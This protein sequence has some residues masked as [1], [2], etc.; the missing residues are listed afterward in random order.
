MAEHII[1]VFEN[2]VTAASAM[3]S[4]IG[5]GIS[6]G[7]IRQYTLSQADREGLTSN[8]TTTTEHHTGGGFW[9]WL[10]GEGPVSEETRSA[11]ASDMDM[12]DNRVRAGNCIVS[13]MV[14]DSMIHQT[15]EVI[16]Q[17]SPVNI[18]E[19]TDEHGYADHPGMTGTGALPSTASGATITPSGIGEGSTGYDAAGAAP[20][21]CPASAQ[22]PMPSG[23]PDPAIGAV[24][25]GRVAGTEAGI[26]T[27]AAH[28]EVIPLSE[29]Q[30]EV[31]K[32]TV[33]LGTTRV[34]RYVVE[35]P[36]EQDVTLRG[37]RVTV[38]RRR[39]LGP[40][41]APGPGTF[42]ERVVEVRETGEEAVVAKTAK[43][44]EEVVIARETTERTETVRD[45]VRK[46]E[47]EITGDRQGNQTKPNI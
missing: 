26:A 43:V 25:I 19:H 22:A 47:V 24:P 36:V 8:T 17:H 28:E 18:D 44:V 5:I 27:G 6:Q 34:R 35:K 11:Y 13:V 29:E 7:A 20:A 38:E 46:E 3:Q 33:D 39:T 4:L 40:D 23:L 15:I 1:A 12:Y 16:N 9:A 42:E 14:D 21:T 41:E 31:G 2:E 45:T 30:L 37:E 32:R 10:F